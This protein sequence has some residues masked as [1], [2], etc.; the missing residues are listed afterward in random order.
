MTTAARWPALGTTAEVRCPAAVLGPARAV[1]EAELAAIDAAASR[2]RDDSELMAVNRAG[3]H[4]VAIS[5]LLAE[6]IEV[7]LWTAAATSGAVDPTVGRA[8]VVAGYD[9]D[10]DALRPSRRPLRA[11][12]VGGW[13]SVALD[14][15]AGTVRVP[16]GVSLD[17][18]ASAKALAA[19]R[20]ASAA[21]A[22]TGAAVLVSLGGDIAV[23]GPAPAGGWPVRVCEDH[24]SGP[25]APGQTLSIGGGG[26]ATSSTTTRRWRR[27]AEDAHHI[28]DP[29][30][31]LPVRAVW[32]TASVAAAS[33]VHANAASTAAIVLR[34]RGARPGW[35][36]PVSRRGWSAP[37]AGCA[38]SATGRSPARPGARRRDRRR[39]RPSAL[40][41]LT[42]GSGAVTLLL[43]TASL[44]LGIVHVQRGRAGGAPR[45]LV[46]SAHRT[47]SL[48]VLV[49]L[50]LHVVTAV[51]DPF[52]PIRLLDAFLPFTSAY[53]PLWLGLGAVALDLLLALT[54]TSVLRARLGHRAWRAVHW[55][56][57]ACW[58][59]AVVH[60][61]GTGS[62]ART[63]W[64]LAL[65]LGC[66]A[67]VVVALALRLAA[68]GPGRSLQ[69]GGAAAVIAAA[70][71]ALAALAAPGT[72]GRRLGAAR[73][74]PGLA[75]G[76]P[77]RRRAP[78]ARRRAVA[79][80]FSVAVSGTEHDG[81]ASDGT[82][83]VDLALRGPA[84]PR[85]RAGAPGRPAA[86]RRGRRPGP[87][88]GDAAP[89]GDRVERADRAA[90]TATS[91]TRS[92]A[93]PTDGALRVRLN[94][95]L[96]GPVVRGQL[97]GRPLQ[98]R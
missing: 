26:L 11:V 7:A 1:V 9:R 34:R 87:Q 39:D 22:R 40:W 37:T 24:R 4:A 49:V 64:L 57:Y 73:R 58:P 62:D 91:S 36:G 46:E 13:R 5:A 8:L 33:C 72:A 28:I 75:A 77:R 16:A 65:A 74:H 3:G 41:Y 69:R 98:V 30:R 20:A 42:R 23:A 92:S 66:V 38:R 6:A 67:A 35:R 45:L 89:P 43:L 95:D 2:F 53:R 56:A 48:L 60:G 82:A 78:T 93:R 12:A 68:S 96:S 70:A 79:R 54:V 19:D 80:P 50:A 29:A 44:V 25:D 32:R 59:V 84:R 90:A 61:L 10:F 47:I 85:A 18:G 63:T 88:R 14:R 51:L 81:Q 15:A 71:A 21:A 94:L 97:Q 31:G 83:V 52:A 76:R 86:G 17:L 27:G 55:A